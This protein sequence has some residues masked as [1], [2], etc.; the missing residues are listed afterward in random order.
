MVYQFGY[1]DIREDG[2]IFC[3]YRQSKIKKDGYFRE[4]WK[5]PTSWDA[6]QSKGLQKVLK[7]NKTALPEYVRTKR[8]HLSCLLRAAR[9][10]AKKQNIPVDIDLDYLE[11]IAPNQCPIFKIEF[12][13]GQGTQKEYQQGPSLDKIIPEL[14]YVKGNVQII[15]YK[16]NTMKSNATP[17]Q[18]L[19]FSKW[20][21]ETYGTKP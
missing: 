17:E 3:Q 7:Y 12:S 21:Q 10:R 8:G 14:G 4:E 11:S 15:S 9:T 1:G 18:L 20:I 13:W 19:Q 5:S 6:M 2:Y 16:A